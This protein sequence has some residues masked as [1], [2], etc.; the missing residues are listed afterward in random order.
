MQTSKIIEIGGV[1]IGA[2]ISLP[3]SRGWRFVSADDR[4]R[5]ADGCTALTLEDAQVLAR[6]AFLTSGGLAQPVL[7]ESAQNRIT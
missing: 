2:V 4:T 3:G 6:R 7:R 5:A 1:F